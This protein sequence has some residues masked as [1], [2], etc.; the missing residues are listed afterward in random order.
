MRADNFLPLPPAPTT[1]PSRARSTPEGEG[2][3]EGLGPSG[4]TP[5]NPM[6]RPATRKRN[7]QNKAT[8][9]PPS[10]P[11]AKRCQS[12]PNRANA[13]HTRENYKTNPKSTSGQF[14]L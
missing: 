12:A 7:L 3:G 1:M 2:G 8:A 10:Q 4:A 6:Q 11:R 13:R 5:R 9:S 14:P